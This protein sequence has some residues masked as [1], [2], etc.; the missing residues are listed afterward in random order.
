M[1]ELDHEESWVLKNWCFWT[2][3]LEKTLERPLDCKEIQ[4]VNPKG[5]QPWIFIGRTDV[6]AEASI[7]W[8]PDKKNWL[9]GK[10]ADAGE[11]WRQ[12]MKGMIEDE[13]VGYHHW[14]YG[15]KFEEAPEVGNGQGGLVCCSSWGCKESDRTK[16]LN[17]TDHWFNIL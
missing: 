17:W 13:M 15:H 8:P 9:L 14:L 16:L 6:E 10:D 12:E 7:L 3:L 5:N 2:V 4:P 1:W 11:D